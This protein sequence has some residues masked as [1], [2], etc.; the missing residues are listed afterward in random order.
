MGEPPIT[1]V[2]VEPVSRLDVALYSAAGEFVGTLARLRDLLPGTYSFGLT[3]RGPD[4][5]ELD[6]GRYEVRLTA[7]P[8]LPARP[9]RA[10]VR[11]RIQ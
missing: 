6:P 11:F 5:T 3:G 8:T 10:R 1:G 4:S 9:S 7:W 2:Q